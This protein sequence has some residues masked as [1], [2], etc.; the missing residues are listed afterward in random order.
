MTSFDC[1]V[2]YLQEP[3]QAFRPFQFDSQGSGINIASICVSHFLFKFLMNRRLFFNKKL[4]AVSKDAKFLDKG[5]FKKGVILNLV[6][7]EISFAPGSKQLH[8]SGMVIPPSIGN[9]Y[10]GY[11]NPYYWDDHP[12]I[13]GTN[14]S[15]DPS[16]IKNQRNTHLMLSWRLGSNAIGWAKQKRPAKNPSKSNY[17]IHYCSSCISY[18]ARKSSRFS[19]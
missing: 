17:I 14:G 3:L 6:K 12:L 5:K 13:Q 2:G 18:Q 8:I 4:G 1:E 9:A 16:A 10:N 7:V 15:L 19:G 11:I